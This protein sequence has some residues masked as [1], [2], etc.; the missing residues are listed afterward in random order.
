[1]DQIGVPHG[2]K[3]PTLQILPTVCYLQGCI[4]N[5]MPMKEIV[6]KTRIFQT[7]LKG[8]ALSYFEHHLRKRFEAQDS[9][10]PDYELIE[11]VL[12]EL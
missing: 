5:L 10:A 3:K 4:V 2:S 12:R 7:L 6:G 1:V 8:Q 11:L 9:E